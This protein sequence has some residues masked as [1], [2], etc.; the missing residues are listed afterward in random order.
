MTVKRD[1][2]DKLLTT[3]EVAEILRVHISSVYAMLGTS[4]LRG[5]KIRNRWR[6][7]E[8]EV[9]RV[10]DASRSFQERIKR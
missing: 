5:V 2:P 8:S 7:P 3:Q 9:M 4:S 6:I 10:T 1:K